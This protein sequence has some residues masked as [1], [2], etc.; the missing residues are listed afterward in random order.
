MTKAARTGHE[1]AGMTI[2]D[3]HDSRPGFFIE[4]LRHEVWVTC[5]AF[6]VRYETAFALRKF[7]EGFPVREGGRAREVE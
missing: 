3:N 2:S 6:D 4:A 5:L 1:K 7:G